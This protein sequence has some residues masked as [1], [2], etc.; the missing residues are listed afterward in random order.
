MAE[1][2]A[3]ESGAGKRWK[4]LSVR[5]ITRISS[6]NRKSEISNFQIPYPSYQNGG[7]APMNRTNFSNNLPQRKLDI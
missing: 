1:K 4:I 6:L 5:D 2:T 3:M 7:K